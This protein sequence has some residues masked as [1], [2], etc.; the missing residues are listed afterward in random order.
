MNTSAEYIEE[1]VEKLLCLDP[2]RI[3]LFGSRASET[4]TESS[5]FDFL[6]V[7]DSDALPQTYQEK[8]RK[9]LLVRDQLMDI[10]EHVPIDL[11]VYTRAEYDILEKNNASFLKEIQKT[12]KILY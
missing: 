4:C 7:L 6:I 10:N 5:D 2:Y 8:M 3:V 11:I 12:G 9:K 1:I